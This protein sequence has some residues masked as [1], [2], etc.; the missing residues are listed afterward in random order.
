[1]RTPPHP[2]QPCSQLPTAI[3]WS[4]M[5]ATEHDAVKKFAAVGERNGISTTL[6]LTAVAACDAD[7][8]VAAAAAY[9]HCPRPPHEAKS[10]AARPTAGDLV[11]GTLPWVAT[12]LGR[13]VRAWVPVVA[14]FVQQSMCRSLRCTRVSG[15]S[16]QRG[17][18]D[19]SC[20]IVHAAADVIHWVDVLSLLAALLVAYPVAL[21]LRWW[22]RRDDRAI[23]RLLLSRKR[24]GWDWKLSDCRNRGRAIALPSC[25]K[26]RIASTPAQQ[27]RREHPCPCPVSRILLGE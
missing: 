8:A 1:M 3:P 21:A 7:G 25:A 17:P 26:R 20:G 15:A 22:Q 18:G 2:E 27:T 13:E 14:R 12:I 23:T 10:R 6:Y 5:P 11:M 16:N 19:T 24:R 9:A 4:L